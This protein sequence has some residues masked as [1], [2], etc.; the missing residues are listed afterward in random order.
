MGHAWERG[1]MS[2]GYWWKRPK[3]KDHLKDLGVGG[4]MGSKWTLRRF[5]GEV[6]SGFT[7]LRIG[8]AG[9]LL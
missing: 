6:L 8:I 4:R 2:A 9:G 3:E 7:W 5:A 1:E